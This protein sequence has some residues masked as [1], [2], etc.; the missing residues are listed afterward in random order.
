MNAYKNIQSSYLNRS[1]AIANL[2]HEHSLKLIELILNQNKHV[3]ESSHKRTHDLLTVKDLSNVH[4]LVTKDVANQ[5]QDYTNFATSAYQLGCKANSEFIENC[6]SH[7]QEQNELTN[8]A[9]KT[10]TN[11]ENP[12]NSLA[13]TFAKAT[14][15]AS[16]LAI[17]TAKGKVKV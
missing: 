14:L 13:N 7:C 17:N 4:Q 16:N 5:V 10:I 1:L 8:E 12:I 15:D 2:Y 9:L 11:S 6:K 3:L